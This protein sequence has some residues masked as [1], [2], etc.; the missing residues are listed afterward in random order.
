MRRNVI[1]R[2]HGSRQPSAVAGRAVQGEE[3]PAH[4]ERVGQV[5]AAGV[6]LIVAEAAFFGLAMCDHPLRRLA[7]LFEGGHI[8]GGGILRDQ[9]CDRPAVLAGV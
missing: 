5:R 7:R 1:R 2:R 3:R 6:G 8:A 9:P 4:V